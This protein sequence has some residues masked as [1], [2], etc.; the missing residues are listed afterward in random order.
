[1]KLIKTKNKLDVVIK[2]PFFYACLSIYPD[3][4]WNKSFLFL[5]KFTPISLVE[6]GDRSFV[7]WSEKKQEARPLTPY[8]A[9]GHTQTDVLD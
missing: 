5:K 8:P 4:E 1:M 9:R 7:L 6:R 3:Y 2:Y